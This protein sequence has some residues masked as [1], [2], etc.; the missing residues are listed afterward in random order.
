MNKRVTRTQS[1]IETPARRTSPKK[2][3]TVDAAIAAIAT[4]S[5]E[6]RILIAIVLMMVVWL[7]SLVGVL[8]KPGTSNSSNFSNTIALPEVRLVSSGGIRTVESRPVNQVLGAACQTQPE[9]PSHLQVERQ[10]QLVALRTKQAKQKFSTYTP[11]QVLALAHPT[12]YGDRFAKDVWGRPVTN[13]PIVVLHETVGT[14]NGVIGL[15]QTPHPRDDDQAS[16]HAL[17]ALD[18]TVVYLVPPEKRAFGAGNSVFAGTPGGEAIQTNAKFPPSVNN[19]AYHISL[20]TPADGMHNGNRHSGYTNAQY[21]SLGWL[22][23]KT[24]VADNR[25]AT[26]KAVDRSG[27]RKDPRSFNTRKFLQSLYTY[28][29]VDEIGLACAVQPSPLAG[30]H[31]LPQPGDDSS[32]NSPGQ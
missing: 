13:L 2:C 28:P 24:G 26:H 23:A 11:R 31:L 7:V 25:L 10:R 4:L 17:I 12:N 18:G 6:L 27:S 30:E 22:V 9:G 14:A 29:R 32:G 3:T 21:R 5:M 19:F 1:L 16:Y 15:F 8:I 20:E